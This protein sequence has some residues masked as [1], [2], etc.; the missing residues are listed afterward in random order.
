[1]SCSAVEM[2]PNTPPQGVCWLT[3][4]AV[5][6]PLLHHSPLSTPSHPILHLGSS[7]LCKSMCCSGSKKLGL[8][9]RL[10]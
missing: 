10:R 8:G 3:S 4:W 1:M 2:L 7:V 5:H 6:P 9:L